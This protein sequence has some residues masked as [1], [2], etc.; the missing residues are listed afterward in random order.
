M[1]LPKNQLNYLLDNIEKDNIVRT[2]VGAI[3][4]RKGLVLLLKRHPN[5]TMGGLV[6]LP[7]GEVDPDEGIVEALKREVLEE[8]G[9]N[10]KEIIFFVGSFD[11]L[12]NSVKSRQLNFLVTAEAGQVQINEVEHTDYY[13][14]D[15]NSQDYKSANISNEVKRVIKIAQNK[16]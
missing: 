8:T 13:W 12:S 15:T 2:M 7:S 10:I 4:Q 1:S 3:I 5:D 9:L 11:Y 6:E 14:L 16:S